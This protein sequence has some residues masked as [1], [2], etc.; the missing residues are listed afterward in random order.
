M[1]PTVNHTSV[2]GWSGTHYTN[3]KIPKNL[4][5]SAL[6]ILF[7]VAGIVVAGVGQPVTVTPLPVNLNGSDNQYLPA[8]A[9]SLEISRTVCDVRNC[10]FT[11]S[12]GDQHIVLSF[13]RQVNGIDR[14]PQEM[15]LEQQ[16]V[17]RNWLSDVSRAHAP[18]NEVEVIQGGTVIVR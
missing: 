2:M 8:W 13:L 7:F 4:I 18:R 11:V 14:T 12:G 10:R 1:L 9:R 5:L 17:L 16:R 6:F 15:Q 3:M